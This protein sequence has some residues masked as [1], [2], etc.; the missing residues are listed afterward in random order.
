ML[1]VLALAL[2][3]LAAALPA[4]A[5]FTI[6]GPDTSRVLTISGFGRASADTDRAVLRIAFETEGETIDEAI[7]KH[8]TEVAR[9]RALLREAG[10]PD[11]D[12]KL[13]R[14]AAGPADGGM[15]FESVRP[16]G[17]EQTFTASRVL[18]ARVDR[19]E[20]VPRLMAQVVQ[21]EADDLLDI[22]R[23]NVD[24]RYSVREPKALED[25][26]LRDAVARAHARAELVAAMAGVEL[27]S[28]LSV[29]EG[30]ASLLGMQSMA[31]MY[32]DGGDSGLTDGEYVVNAAVIVTYRIR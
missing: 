24:V 28:I 26:A 6:A 25:E 15:T 18:V 10:I 17:D 7:Q 2:L 16:N 29:D 11:A 4:R 9:V 8:E 22:Q 20:I 14:A 1:R 30:N 27:G 19:L 12:V 13:E 23:R 3:C 31:A 32:R 21:N 5:Q